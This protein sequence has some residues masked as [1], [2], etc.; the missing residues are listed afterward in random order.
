MYLKNLIWTKLEK[1]AMR[2]EWT[3][4]VM[5]VMESCVSDKAE[6]N[7]HRQTAGE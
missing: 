2:V 1:S 4:L 3:I 7:Y 6:R 5:H